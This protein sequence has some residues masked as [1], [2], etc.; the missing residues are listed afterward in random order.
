MSVVQQIIDRR[1]RAQTTSSSSYTQRWQ[2]DSQLI[3]R[4]SYGNWLGLAQL[5]SI[6]APGLRQIGIDSMQQGRSSQVTCAHCGNTFAK[7]PETSC[8][9]CAGREFK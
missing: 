4:N 7:R 6:Y 3:A 8:P 9:G 1:A 2:Q 5:S